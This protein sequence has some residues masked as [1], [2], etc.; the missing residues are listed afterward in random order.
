MMNVYPQNESNPQTSNGTAESSLT[1]FNLTVPRMYSGS[2]ASSF[3]CIRIARSTTR[4]VT[5]PS[6]RPMMLL[7][8]EDEPM[9]TSICTMLGINLNLE[10]RYKSVPSMN[11][12]N[13]ES[14]FTG[15]SAA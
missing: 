4:L 2:S 14:L 12:P 10:S 13:N 6:T 7:A 1:R 5:Y 15:R 11:L 8:T 9:S 3:A